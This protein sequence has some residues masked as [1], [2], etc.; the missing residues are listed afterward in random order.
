MPA[1]DASAIYAL[2]ERVRMGDGDAGKEV[3]L[4]I[5]PV[6]RARVTRA[7]R[8][9]GRGRA[10]STDVE[11][12]SQE[13]F[14]RL[15][16]GGARALRAWDP[17]RGLPF[18]GFVGMLTAREVAMALRTR[19]RDPWFEEPTAADPLS[20][21]CGVDGGGARLEAR[22]EL[23]HVLAR[24]RLRLSGAGWSYLTWL[25]LEDRPVT[26]IAVETGATHDAIYMWRTRIKRLLCEIH[27][28]LAREAGVP[29][30]RAVAAS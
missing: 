12:L 23:R 19:T 9:R 14:A 5:A 27:G 25:V 18:L 15:F 8:R 2:L 22:D 4:E 3:F 29:I 28:E 1:L 24:A 6:V 30:R 17:A 21:L 7:L 20:L 11:D 16:V 13:T 26:A 10:R